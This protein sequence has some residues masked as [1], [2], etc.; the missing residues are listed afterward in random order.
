VST[1]GYAHTRRNDDPATLRETLTTAGATTVFCDDQVPIRA[2]WPQLDR[3]LATLQPGDTLIVPRLIHLGRSLEH[4][5]EL[6]TA[7]DQRGI[8]FRALDEQFDT[9]EHGQQLLD[10]MHGLVDAR[11]AWRSENT[12][13]G[14]AVA[15]AAG[16]KP[17]RPADPGLT[18]Q[19][20]DLAGRLRESGRPVSDIADLLG[21]SRPKLYRLLQPEN[22][23]P[24]SEDPAP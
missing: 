11:R 3:A 23:P 15:A 2:H 4:L 7:L 10:I 14:L 18:A 21:V 5:A 8:R 9:A 6:I 12:K 20:S 13:E 16:R 22:P 17:G 24:T 1:I 19:Q